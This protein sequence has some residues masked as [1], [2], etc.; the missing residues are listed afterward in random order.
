M[1]WR[2]WVDTTVEQVHRIGPHELIDRVPLSRLHG[3]R[4]A[5]AMRDLQL[6]DSDVPRAQVR[7][8]S[9]VVLL[10]VYQDRARALQVTRKQ[11]GRP[12]LTSTQAGDRGAHPADLPDQLRAQHLDIAQR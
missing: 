9:G 4:R 6:M 2:S 12:L 11:D 1:H 7:D 8:R 3:E 10:P 5:R